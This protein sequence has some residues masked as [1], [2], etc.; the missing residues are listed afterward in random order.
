[1]NSLKI[2]LYKSKKL[3]DGTFPIYIRLIVNK[4]TKYLPIYKNDKRFRALP[5][6]WDEKKQRLKKNNKINPEHIIL[7]KI[8]D[9]RELQLINLLQNYMSN[10]VVLNIKKIREE[11]YN[12]RQTDEVLSFI[13]STIENCKE[14]GTISNLK[15]LRK[16]LKLFNNNG[17][18]NFEEI[19]YDCVNEFIRYLKSRNLSNTTIAIRL[20]Y[21]RYILNQSIKYKVGNK[22]SY[23]FSGKYG[24][25]KIIKISQF[26]NNKRKIAINKDL[27][28]VIKST[29]CT[30]VKDETVRRLFISSYAARGM[31]FKDMAFV[32]KEN[33]YNA[34]GKHYLIYNRNKTGVQINLRINS[35]LQEQLDWFKN[36]T[37]LAKDSLFPILQRK[38]IKD[39][40]VYLHNRLNN[41]NYRLKKI[42]KNMDLDL[43]D[44]K[45]SSY[46]ARHSFATNLFHN[47]VN[48]NVIS[49]A[50][51]HKSVNTTAFYLEKFT[52]DQISDEI[53]NVIV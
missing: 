51:A 17:R 31:N 35:L 40:E 45:I 20:R 39:I 9:N 13:E 1:M 16:D 48:I 36:N 50:L 4:K 29:E 34:N 46:A 15:V 6:Q 22:E 5:N 7:N 38:S 21:L 18:I 49:Q 42:V 27:I 43:G 53:E 8:L 33:I 19:D 37:T 24:A 30:N 25:T 3:S 26:E 2:I 44:Q 41:Y 47:G 52:D 32:K 12:T 28:D 11:F 10:K 23:P 14:A